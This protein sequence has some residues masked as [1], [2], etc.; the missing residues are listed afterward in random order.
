[1]NNLFYNI[2]EQLAA[3]PGREED[4]ERKCSNAGVLNENI[5]DFTEWD[6]RAAM[7]VENQKRKRSNILNRLYSRYSKVRSEREKRELYS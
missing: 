2:K 1:M 7:Y 3:N 6:L 4:Y 5:M